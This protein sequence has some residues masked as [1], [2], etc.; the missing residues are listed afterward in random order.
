MASPPFHNSTQG[1][2][3]RRPDEQGQVPPPGQ[4]PPVAPGM[5]EHQGQDKG[6][7]EDDG[8]AQG[9]HQREQGQGHP[10]KAES[11]EGEGEGGQ[12]QDYGGCDFGQHSAKAT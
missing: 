4:V 5:V 2:A 3:R 9:H 7:V 6:V 8:L 12:S 11:G 10:G 1:H